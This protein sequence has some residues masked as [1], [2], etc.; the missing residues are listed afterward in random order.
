MIVLIKRSLFDGLPCEL[1]S[2]EV[3]TRHPPQA[4]ARLSLPKSWPRS[5]DR[6]VRSTGLPRSAYVPGWVRPRLYAGD[7]L[8]L[9]QNPN[10]ALLQVTYL[11][12]EA[13]CLEAQHLRLVRVTTLLTTVHVCWPYHPLDRSTAGSGCGSFSLLPTQRCHSDKWRSRQPPSR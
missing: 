7:C 1:W 13:F 10:Q 6:S 5:L 3:G 9:R 2:H 4:S 11:L 8:C 12:V